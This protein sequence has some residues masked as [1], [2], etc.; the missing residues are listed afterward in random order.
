MKIEKTLIN[1]ILP[2]SLK[3]ILGTFVCT[4][5]EYNIKF[6]P[7]YCRTNHFSHHIFHPAVHNVIKDANS[8]MGEDTSIPLN[9]IYEQLVEQRYE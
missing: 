4:H 8:W 5:T 1:K 9:F 2:I 3:I 6:G 7:P